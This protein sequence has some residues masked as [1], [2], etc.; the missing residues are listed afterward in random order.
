M[1]M[2]ADVMQSANAPTEQLDVGAGQFSVSS[3]ASLLYLPGGIF[4]S[5]ERS[6][7]WVDRTDAP[8]PLPLP[9]RAYLSPRLSPDGQRV[10]FWTQ[11]DRN[12]WVHDFTRHDDE[13]HIR[14]EKRTSHLD[15]GRQKRDLRIDCRRQ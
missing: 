8:K 10:V 11:G 15:A 1:A 9:A 2:I 14:G 7:V 6:L 13:G 3:S 12:I 4:P 5:P